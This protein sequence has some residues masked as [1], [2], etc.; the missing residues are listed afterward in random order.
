[1]TWWPSREARRET[2]PRPES[3]FQVKGFSA[4]V[5]FGAS[6]LLRKT[7]G[8]G[9]RGGGRMH[10]GRESPA[11]VMHC[12]GGGKECLIMTFVGT[13]G[14]TKQGVH[15]PPLRNILWC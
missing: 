7:V 15:S 1:M 8:G 6:P 11:Q 13:M 2:W 5:G 14:F 12:F 9:V 3:V 10:A 4:K